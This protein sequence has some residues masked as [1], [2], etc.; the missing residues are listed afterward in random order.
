[1]ATKLLSNNHFWRFSSRISLKQIS[2]S[3]INSFSNHL[4][5]I[6]FIFFDS[7]HVDEI[8]LEYVVSILEEL[9]SDEEGQEDLFDVESFSEMLT[10]YFPDFATIS[11]SS[12]CDWIFELAVQLSK[13]K[14]GEEILKL[15]SS[16]VAN[17]CSYMQMPR[18]VR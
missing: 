9:G 14:K 13:S 2:G 10:A 1:M 7:S 6:Y 12:I 3:I 15:N 17:D 11:H 18:R 8:V 5:N 16:Q 4:L